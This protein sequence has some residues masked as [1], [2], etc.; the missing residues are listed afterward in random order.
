MRR[1]L[2]RAGLQPLS[3][4]AHLLRH[5]LATSMLRA[6]ASMSE[7][8]QVLRHQDP[9]T[10]DIYVKVDIKGLRALAQP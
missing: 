5:S 3:K 1:G 4:G 9:N 2:Q 8:G 7:I 10:T 6:G